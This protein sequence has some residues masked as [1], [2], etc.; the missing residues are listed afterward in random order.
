MRSQLRFVMHPDDENEFVAE[1]LRDSPVV[2]IDGP[3][4]KTPQPTVTKTITEIGSYCIIWSPSDLKELK[5]DF[6]PTCNDWYCR[7][8]FATIQFLR[9]LV[10]DDRIKDGRIAIAT[11]EKDDGCPQN[12]ERR[13]KT[14]SKYI[15][16]RYRNSVIQ[17]QNLNAPLVLATESR[18]ENPSEPDN[19]LWIG[20]HAMSWLQAD[21]S[22]VVGQTA[23]G[24]VV[25]RLCSYA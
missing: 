17:W 21:P 18:S 15:K 10:A 7:S 19:S 9:S 24:P 14:L 4:W 13:Y 20:P 5:A 1:V 23:K 11:S 3:R 16:K 22:H 2:L 25:G 6:I 12:V 8:E